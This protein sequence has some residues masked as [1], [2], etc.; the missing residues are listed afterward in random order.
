MCVCIYIYMYILQYI[1]IYIYTD[2]LPDGRTGGRGALRA[3]ARREEQA[4]G[5]SIISLVCFT[6]MINCSMIIVCSV[7][8]LLLLLS[9]VFD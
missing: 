7:F 1:Y 5:P 6:I 9:L 3:A 2:N 8:V 4:L